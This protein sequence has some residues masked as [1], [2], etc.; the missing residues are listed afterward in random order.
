[1]PDHGVLHTVVTKL[2]ICCNVLEYAGTRALQHPIAALFIFVVAQFAFTYRLLYWVTYYTFVLIG[3]IVLYGW[4]HAFQRRPAGLPAA[5]VTRRALRFT[6]PRDWQAYLER[7]RKESAPSQRTALVQNAS[8]QTVLDDIQAYILRDFIASWFSQYITPDPTFPNHVDKLLYRA[9]ATIKNRLSSVDFV[10]F[11][12]NR[13]VPLLTTHI[14]EYHRAEQALRGQR[15]QR[16][17]T[18]SNELDCQ[19]ASQYRG[20][21]LH[22]A[23]SANPT[24]TVPLEL[25]Y[26]RHVVE[27]ILPLIFPPEECRSRI[28]RVLIREILVCKVLLPLM[29]M[30]VAPDYWNQMICLL[31]QAMVQEEQVLLRKIREALDRDS[32]LE[33]QTSSTDVPKRRTFEEFVK[34]IKQCDNLLDALRIRDMISTELLTKRREIANCRSSDI[35]NGVKVADTRIYLNRLQVALKRAEKRI[36]ALGG[37]S[38]VSNQ[39]PTLNRRPDI[40]EILLDPLL[41]SYFT[42]YMD[43]EGRLSYLQCWMTLNGLSKQWN[44]DEM[45]EESAS[46]AVEAGIFREDLAGVYQEHF[47]PNAPLKVTVDD[48]LRDR[49]SRLAYATDAN[50]TDSVAEALQTL[51]YSQ[52]QVF[53]VLEREDYVGFL[54][55]NI[56]RRLLAHR[57]QDSA[58]EESFPSN[59]ANE[60]SKSGLSSESDRIPTQLD[61]VPEVMEKQSKPLMSMFRNRRRKSSWQRFLG[62]ARPIDLIPL[63]TDSTDN[64][65]AELTAILSGDEDAVFGKR[66]LLKKKSRSADRISGAGSDSELSRTKMG[67]LS[68]PEDDTCIAKPSTSGTF[69]GFLRPKLMRSLSGG[70]TKKSSKSLKFTKSIDTLVDVKRDEVTGPEPRDINADVSAQGAELTHEILSFPRDDMLASDHTITVQP[71]TSEWRRN[72]QEEEEVNAT[73]K[74]PAVFY[75]IS[76]QIKKHEHA[77]RQLQATIATAE[78]QDM[79]EERLQELQ[80][81]RLGLITLAGQAKQRRKALADQLRAEFLS[82]PSTTVSIPSHNVHTSLSK[83]YAVFAIL[84]SHR[85]TDGVASE[86]FVQRRYSEFF[87]LHQ[88]LKQKWPSVGRFNF[89]GKVLTGVMKFRKDAVEDRRKGLESW[90]KAVMSIREICRYEP[91]REFVC[92]QE[93]LDSLF[94]QLASPED[95]TGGTPSAANV[96][97]NVTV[98]LNQRRF[99]RGEGES[100]SLSSSYLDVSTEYPLQ[101]SMTPTSQP[102]R[103]PVLLKSPTG[104]TSTVDIVLDLL[105][106]L[107][108]LNARTNWLRRQ[109]I[110]LL[111]QNLFGGAVERR[112]TE[113]VRVLAEEDRLVEWLKLARNTVWPEGQLP[114]VP[115]QQRTGDQMRRAKL[116]A[117]SR[118]KYIV[119]ELL[120]GIVGRQ[121]AKKGAGRIWSAVQN[122]RLNRQ[123]AYVMLDEI[124]RW[125]FPEVADGDIR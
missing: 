68:E 16:S 18:E 114:A 99:T 41:L 104:A 101:A 62:D 75:E 59:V 7:R 29:D 85:N 25:A 96:T 8:I 115:A 61:S 35:I 4:W 44:I 45:D 93:V 102:Q 10:Q 69:R 94:R 46:L 119:P 21:R 92:G 72:S 113:A 103:S 19:L 90:L 121:N 11:V 91:V 51:Q 37:R 97:N 120:G 63:R 117:E 112:V 106:E 43:Q 58:G 80:L 88:E 42:E 108:D 66:S 65:E 26:L 116:E 124:V 98:P 36:V 47:A 78:T 52:L 34:M 49:L 74:L 109:A 77:E 100:G 9:L 13:A 3:A 123:I 70:S 32:V 84:V 6:R 57:M 111:L 95:E 50:S 79:S 105:I 27:K 12:I 76:S 87:A 67:A 20:G 2:R 54:R 33:N 82:P 71:T 38:K 89:P 55:S 81:M 22:P 86:W 56:Y 24:P 5:P 28:F 40:R 125:I 14:T 122:Q 39:A 30:L 31:T 23:I 118:L 1:M 48:G 107:F 83:K 60:A 53:S 17:V 15:L 73:I 110:A 64:V